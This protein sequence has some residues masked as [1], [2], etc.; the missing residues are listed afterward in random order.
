MKSATPRFANEG[1][2]FPTTI[3]LDRFARKSA[4]KTKKKGHFPIIFG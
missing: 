4:R 3:A 1:C 2:G